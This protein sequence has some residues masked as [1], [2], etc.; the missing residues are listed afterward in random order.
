[1]NWKKRNF[2]EYFYIN[3]LSFIEKLTKLKKKK[4]EGEGRNKNKKKKQHISK[5]LKY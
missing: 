2:Y 1:M 4:K 5:S 3:V